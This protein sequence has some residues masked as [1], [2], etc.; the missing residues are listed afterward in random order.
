M[1]RHEAS[2]AQLLL[3]AAVLLGGGAGLGW[4]LGRAV[5]YGEGY[6]R[7][8]APPIE[9]EMQGRARMPRWRGA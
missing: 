9:Q 2:T 5:G 7:G 4:I 6:Q 3:L 8:H 1:R